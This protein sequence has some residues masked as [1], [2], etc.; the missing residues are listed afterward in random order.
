MKIKELNEKQRLQVIRLHHQ[1]K[2][3]RKIAKEFKFIS[4]KGAQKIIKK[5]KEHKIINLPRTGRPKATT[6]RE[7]RLI[8][9]EAL[10]DDEVT[11]EE[12]KENLNWVLYRIGPPQNLHESDSI[13]GFQGRGVHFRWSRMS[14]MSTS[15][16][17]EKSKISTAGLKEREAIC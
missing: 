9:L 3:S 13:R 14:E 2:S 17:I 5:Y 4:Y 1:D 8:K 12:I 10:K 15:G 7:N 6:E 11:A 16:D